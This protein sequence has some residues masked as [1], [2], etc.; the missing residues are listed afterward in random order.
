MSNM[1][2]EDSLKFGKAGNLI[3][4]IAGR[5]AARAAQIG[6]ENIFNFSIGNPN[7]PAP[8]V[9]TDT[10]RHLLDTEPPETLHAY[11]AAPGAFPVREAVAAYLNK[12]FGVSY[13]ADD[14]YLTAGASAALAIACKAVLLP[15]DEVIIFAPYYPEYTV[16]SS[17]FG[18]VPVILNCREEDFQID[19]AQ[20][21]AA[22]TPKTK[23]VII[24]SPN[25]PSGAVLSE[26]TIIAMADL[27]RRKQAEYGSVIYLLADEPYRELVYDGAVIPFVPKYYDNTLLCYSYSKCL[28]IPG[29]R[30]GYILVPPQVEN[31]RDVYAA[32]CGAGRIL[33]YINNSSL[34]QYML[35]TCLG[36]TSDLSV[37]TTNRRLLMDALKADGY[38]MAQP[39]GAFYLFVKAFEPDDVA[40][41]EKARDFDLFLVPG[42]CFGYPGYVRIAY[43]V[44]TEMVQKSLPAFRA[45]AA[46]YGK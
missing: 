41:C 15:G 40:F 44:S 29:E 37:Y 43:C 35:P 17:C 42:Y 21:E 23:M 1:L 14:L 6:A 4:E 28:A 46:A 27:L 2:P 16:Y 7:V 11:T 13:G 36:A 39:D 32:V 3:R 38:Q 45:L 33:G 34:L 9:V 18:G 5:A 25:N 24:N 20:L 10:L 12:T 30:M 19:M 26:E 31:S 22:I 8:A